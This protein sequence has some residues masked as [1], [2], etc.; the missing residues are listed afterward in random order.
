MEQRLQARALT[1][2]SPSVAP[3][4]ESNCDLGGGGLVEIEAVLRGL[5]SAA[6]PASEP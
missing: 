3:L 1:S 5:V 4:Q 2:M 6:N